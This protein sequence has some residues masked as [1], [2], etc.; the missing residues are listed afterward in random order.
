MSMDI[1]SGP[2]RGTPFVNTSGGMEISVTDGKQVVGVVAEVLEHRR[3]RLGKL[4]GLA[5]MPRHGKTEFAKQVRDKRKFAQEDIRDYAA[6]G[7]TYGNMVN[8]YFLPANPRR[9]VL[10]DLAGEDFQEFGR[11]ASGIPEVM[12]RVLWPVLPALDGLVIFIALP[13]LWAAWNDTDES[14]RFREPQESELRST[15]RATLETINSATLLVKYAMVA[16]QLARV[17]RAH[18]N[19]NLTEPEGHEGFW[20][21]G[22]HAIDEAFPAV[23]PLDIPVFVAFSKSD[24]CETL[25]HPGG[26]RT[27]P[28]PANGAK[29]YHAFVR[30]DAS[31][32][33]ILGMQAFPRLYE[34]LSKY[35]RYFKFD[36]VQAIRDTSAQPDPSV[37]R[38]QSAIPDL[39][40][41]E[42]ALEFVAD[43][44]WTLGSPGT[45][46][47]VEWS[48]RA[49]PDRWT[50][51]GIRKSLGETWPAAVPVFAPDPPAPAAP[52]PAEATVA[53]TPRVYSA[54]PP[55]R[56]TAAESPP[57]VGTR[58]MMPW[59][60]EEPPPRGDGRRD[61]LPE[62]TGGTPDGW[63]DQL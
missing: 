57:P 32:P 29:R 35:V 49:D 53:A 48:Q 31:D 21:P 15:E 39:R 24:L 14:G 34:F 56:D 40:G 4:I 28:L 2:A 45:A 7:K 52:S 9:D 30:P 19:I 22:R 8:I 58:D 10:I 54:L 1:E 23:D 27:P 50:P 6:G 59:S 17:R 46:R 25:T 42:S 47:A 61:P 62:E 11:Y 33:L 55:S 26:L 43:H 12:Q 36:F 41:V 37:L 44:A 38:G 18:P 63:V 16:K 13:Y 3:Q 60:S 20:A 51:D 5:G